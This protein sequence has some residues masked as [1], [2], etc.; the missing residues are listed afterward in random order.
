M[1]AHG[2]SSTRI[3]TKLRRV[4]L[5][6]R[7][8]DSYCIQSH[9]RG[10]LVGGS[11]QSLSKWCLHLSEA[12][13]PSDKR[14][15]SL[16]QGLS[17]SLLSN[18]KSMPECKCPVLMSQQGHLLNLE[19]SL[20]FPWLDAVTCTSPVTAGVCSSVHH[21]PTLLRGSLLSVCLSFLFNV[22][23]LELWFLSLSCFPVISKRQTVRTAWMCPVTLLQG[24]VA[25]AG[26]IKL[27]LWT[28]S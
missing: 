18:C 24:C 27:D 28:W 25:A 7:W 3:K 19:A 9:F 20:E 16:L 23:R 6:S 12:L 1:L 10:L 2:N 21:L 4:V 11:C 5:S 26:L 13:L 22:K 15:F 17:T 8:H 14:M